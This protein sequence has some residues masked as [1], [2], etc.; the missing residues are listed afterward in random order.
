[1]SDHFAPSVPTTRR[2]RA[3]ADDALRLPPAVTASAFTGAAVGGGWVMDSL[4][5]LPASVGAIAAGAATG[6]LLWR[7]AARA[8]SARK[9]VARLERE[10]D[11][12]RKALSDI[13]ADAEKGRQ[14]L[15]RAAAQAARGATN[16]DFTPSAQRART[17]DVCGDAASV[18]AAVLTEARQTVISAAAHQRGMLSEQAELAEIFKSIAPRLQSLVERCLDVISAVEK[19]VADPELMHELFRVDHLVTQMRRVVESLRVLGGSVPSRDSAPVLVVTAIRR[20]IAEIPKYQRVRPAL[21]HERALLPGYVSPNVVHLLAALMENA[22]TYSSDP[23][24]VYTHRATGGVVIELLD[25]GTGIPQEKRDALNRLLAAPENE[26]VPSRLREG[27]IGLLVAALLAKRHNITIQLHPNLVGGTQAIVVIPNQLLIAH[28]EEAPDNRVAGMRNAAAPAGPARPV[29]PAHH[30][31]DTTEL[32][33]IPQTPLE[34]PRP[35]QPTAHGDG[36][37]P[38]PRRTQA[39]QDARVPPRQQVPTGNAT[40]GLMANFRSGMARAQEQTP[41]PPAS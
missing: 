29:R 17:G 23:V 27:Q 32:R 28:A 19:S 9:G 31:D 6:A 41:R 40:T 37:P 34:S 4:G 18:L 12:A 2:R 8:S 21:S 10:H 35:Q 33:R 22:T 24:E 26:D 1:M 36:K 30:S 25:R 20:A 13:I 15:R 39:P 5:V 3:H 14:D 11:A 38:L 7:T 16:A